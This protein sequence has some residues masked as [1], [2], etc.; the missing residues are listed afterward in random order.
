M[1]NDTNKKVAESM[2][3]LIMARGIILVIIGLILLLFPKATLTT[4]IFILGIYWL[5]DGFVTLINTYK[6]RNIR[7]NWWWGLITGSLA[8]IAGIIVVTRPFSS[9]V[10][11]TS[12]FMW[13]L[14]IVALVNGI[15]NVVTGIR[16]K[17]YHNG[18]RSMI[19]GGV[20]SNYSGYHPYFLTLYIGC[21]NCKSNRIICH[22]CRRYNI[23]VRQ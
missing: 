19:W 21:G 20:F 17:K 13:F 14:G 2:W 23:I 8:I 9:S 6:Q 10:L 1:T 16:I 11:T 7:P 22:I 5:I 3:K 12:F 4:L 15:S 18:E